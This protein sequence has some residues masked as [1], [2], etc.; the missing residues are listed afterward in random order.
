MKKV[1]VVVTVVCMLLGMGV[2]A[3]AQTYTNDRMGIAFALSDDWVYQA[4]EDGE[5]YYTHRETPEEGLLI[6]A[7]VMDNAYDLDL[8]GTETEWYTLCADLYSNAELAARLNEAN[9]TT[10]ITIQQKETEGGYVLRGGTK[11]YCF[12]K[13]Y[14][15]SA[16]GFETASFTDVAILTAKNGKLYIFEYDVIGEPQHLSDIGA[17]LETASYTAGETKIFI[18]GERIYPDSAPMIING[19]TLVPIRAVAEKMGYQVG[20]DESTQKVSLVGKYNLSFIIHSD[21]AMKDTEQIA[22]DVPAVLYSSRT[23]LPLRAVAEAMDAQV[24]WSEAENAVYIT[25]VK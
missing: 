4:L 12:A 6:S 21:V 5:I 3:Q 17:M 19:R 1:V 22:L 24:Q 13:E 11:Y 8:L 15:A 18:D 10:E 14:L 16:P 2:V 9:N 25:S 7:I 20:W 23:Y